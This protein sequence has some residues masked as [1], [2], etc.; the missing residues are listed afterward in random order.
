MHAVPHPATPPTQCSTRA[1]DPPMQ[2]RTHGLAAHLLRVGNRIL[3]AALTAGAALDA[4]LDVP[5]RFLLVYPTR[6]GS[7]ALCLG[8]A[9]L[10]DA[11]HAAPIPTPG[12]GRAGGHDARQLGNQL[13]HQ[14]SACIVARQSPG[15]APPLAAANCLGDLAYSQ[16]TGRSFNPG[17]LPGLGGTGPAAGTPAAMYLA[18]V[19]RGMRQDIALP[20]QLSTGEVIAHAGKQVLDAPPLQARIH[21]DA[22]RVIDACDLRDQVDRY[23]FIRSDG[24][25]TVD[26]APCARSSITGP[27]VRELSRGVDALYYQSPLVAD[28]AQYTLAQHKVWAQA[29]EARKVGNAYHLRVSDAVV[30]DIGL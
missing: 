18:L 22:Q 6:A 17:R 23:L 30:D 2:P 26:T 5:R 11:A 13:G 21:A 28:R 9:A 15:I 27:T 14:L 3:Q 4:A 24:E 25:R 19:Q 29:D 10:A 20:V 1:T 7:P 16:A 12:M 8:L